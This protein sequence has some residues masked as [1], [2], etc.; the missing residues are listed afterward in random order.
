MHAH[1]VGL[2]RLLAVALSFV[3]HKNG[4]RILYIFNHVFIM[5]QTRRHNLRA[6][7]LVAGHS[8]PRRLIPILLLSEE[9]CLCKSQRVSNLLLRFLLLDVL[10]ICSLRPIAIFKQFGQQLTEQLLITHDGL[11]AG[12]WA[13]RMMRRLPVFMDAPLRLSNI[14]LVLGSSTILIPRFLIESVLVL[15]IILVMGC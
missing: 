12:T 2:R 11:L 13:P 3:L 1:V 7:W 8:R 4:S 9:R 6:C 15:L 10:C 14:T 5:H